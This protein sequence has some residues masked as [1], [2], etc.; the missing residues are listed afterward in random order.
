MYVTKY[1]TVEKLPDCLSILFSYVGFFIKSIKLI[2]KINDF[3][4]A[5]HM[6]K[7][8]EKLSEN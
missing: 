5:L 2:Y 6:L 8:L 3:K 7:E 1:K 4:I